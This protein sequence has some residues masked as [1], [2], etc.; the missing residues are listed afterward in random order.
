MSHDNQDALLKA[1]QAKTQAIQA[2]QEQRADL[3]DEAVSWGISVAKISKA[4]GITRQAIY[5]QINK[6]EKK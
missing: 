5:Y 1:I 6:K 2:A 3:I 4:S